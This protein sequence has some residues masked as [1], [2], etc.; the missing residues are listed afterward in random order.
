[1]N[2]II[3]AGATAHAPQFFTY[4]PT[5]DPTQLDASIAAMR[6]LGHQMF[7]GTK[8]DAVI[9]IGSDHLETFFLSAVPTFALIGGE[10]VKA[11]FAGRNYDLPCHPMSEALIEHLVAAG[12]DMVYSQDAVLGHAFAAPFEWIMEKRDIPVVA[13]FVNTYL[14][15][16]PTA[17]RC[18][19]LGHAIAQFLGT[20]PERVAIIAS[21]GLSHYPGTWKY[22]EPAYGFDRWAIGQMERGNMEAI[23]SLTNRQID[24]VGN[25]EILS[26]AVMFGALL[27]QYGGQPGELLTYQPTWHHGHAVMRFLPGRETAVDATPLAPYQFANEPHEFYTHPAPSSYNLNRLLYDL[28]HDPALR[29]RMIE[30]PS[31]VAEERKLSPREAAVIDTMLDEDIDLLRNRKTHPVVEAGAHPLGLL[32]SLITVQAEMRRMKKE[33]QA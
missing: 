6:Q 2:Q 7:D 29:R 4:P 5:E 8:P 24:E 33:A 9:V 22:P 11:A 3:A 23:L 20:R 28:R 18:A 31:E 13:M 16:L 19:A 27:E 17:K 25:T 30:H 14:P 10:R 26:W 32:M 12:F 21:G 15:P 1:M